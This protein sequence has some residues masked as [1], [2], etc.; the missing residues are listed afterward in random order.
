MS[1]NIR[2][3]LWGAFSAFTCGALKRLRCLKAFSTASED[4]LLNEGVPTLERDASLSSVPEDEELCNVEE[5]C[6]QYARLS[7]HCVF[8]KGKEGVP[9]AKA[10]PS[11]LSLRV[12]AA[13]LDLASTCWCS[14]KASAIIVIGEI[15][16]ISTNRL[17]ADASCNNGDEAFTVLDGQLQASIC[18]EFIDGADVCAVDGKSGHLISFTSPA[19][20]LG[21]ADFAGARAKL[22][23]TL[24]NDL[25]CIV[26][27]SSKES[28]GIVLLRGS[29]G[30]V[31]RHNYRY[32]QITL[33]SELQNSRKTG[34]TL[35]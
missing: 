4:G 18:K 20:F 16:S 3:P 31:H 6:A 12:Y 7:C 24:S 29:R 30:D 11:T 1:L 10:L 13:C 33:T 34:C 27:V 15:S 35:S 21:T 26:M 8:C 22:S 9:F 19:F 23:Q 32:G 5:D 25:D 14:Q 17:F 2:L 28:G